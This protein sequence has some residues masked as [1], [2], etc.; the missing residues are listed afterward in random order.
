[1]FYEPGKTHHGLPFD[2]FKSCVVPRP[3]AR[4]GYYEYTSIESVF[5]MRIP[6]SN[7]A[8]A[9]GLEGSPLAIAKALG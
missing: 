2:P 4:L 5:E 9:S 6:G 8:L 1:M 7:A 3:I